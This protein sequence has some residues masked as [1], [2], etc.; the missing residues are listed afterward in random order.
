MT[1]VQWQSYDHMVAAWQ[2]LPDQVCDKM[3]DA[4]KDPTIERFS[5]SV[6]GQSFIWKS[7]FNLRDMTLKRQSAAV[8]PVRRCKQSN[9]NCSY[10][11]GF[12]YSFFDSYVSAF[13]ID[14]K[15]YGR[16]STRFYV[17]CN[18][19]D[20][21]LQEPATQLNVT[22]GTVRAIHIPSVPSTGHESDEDLNDEDV[23]FEKLDETVSDMPDTLS[24]PLMCPITQRVML[25]P[26]V[27]A[28]GHTYEK[29]AI[30]RWLM[31]KD[32]SPLTGKKLIDQS[33]RRNHN[34]RALIASFMEKK[35][36]KKKVM[37]PASSNRSALS[38]W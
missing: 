27:A 20:G 9:I 29:E 21:F 5:I 7:E 31:S 35:K 3:E 38:G 15:A 33:L 23:D 28:D 14:A 18:P 22:T 17:D 34:V 37:R 4:F 10:F 26:V 8:V 2:D 11:D 6:P 13:L 12:A 36:K 1:S 24:K 19:Y 32:K 16:T 25:N 30:V